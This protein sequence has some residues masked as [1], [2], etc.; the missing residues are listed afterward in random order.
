MAPRLGLGGGVTADPASGLF[1]T[2][3]P[4]PLLDTFPNAHRAYS[5]RKLRT[6]YTGYAM[7]VRESGS[8]YTADV[9]FDD[10][11]YVSASSLV[12]N[13]SDAS[14]GGPTLGA[15]IGGSN[16][17]YVH[18][19]Y[20]QSG[21]GVNA[22]DAGYVGNWSV[23][24]ANQPKIYTS[25]SLITDVTGSGTP[26]AALLFDGSDR[27]NI[28]N[29]GLTLDATSV[30]TTFNITTSGNQVPW[31]LAYQGTPVFYFPYLIGTVM[32]F[33]H[34][35]GSATSQDLAGYDGVTDKRRLYSHLSG[36][37]SQSLVINGTTTTAGSPSYASTALGSHTSYVG[38]G[39]NITTG[40]KG[41]MQE[42]IVYDS[43]QTSNN[44]GITSEIN[45]AL[46]VY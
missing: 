43:N 31:C 29:T 1:A 17:G 23:S 27:L 13:K 8:D 32:H 38:I 16:D 7:K 19:W 39:Y 44:A 3:A 41:K 20:D 11:G 28:V 15:F 5:V 34:D 10:D 24:P 22:I 37:G 2:P 42:F 12:A 6:E 30:F 36:G 45:T 46:E 4:D 40:L 18:T 35:A 26:R 21:E 25:G 9:A 14:A 33:Y